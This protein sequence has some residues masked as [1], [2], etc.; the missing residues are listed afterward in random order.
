[1]WYIRKSDWWDPKNTQ[2]KKTQK[3]E[4]S[5]L[6]QMKMTGEKDPAHIR[7]LVEQIL[8]VCRDTRSTR[9]Y[10]QVARALPDEVIFR[11]LSEIKDD[12]TI[13]NRGAVF[14]SKVKRYL[15]KERDE[16]RS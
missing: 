1:M 3:E 10:S 8:E 14:T 11:F 6:T 5:A 2:M 16:I 15:E 9:F 7:Y 4:Y 13:E 12:K